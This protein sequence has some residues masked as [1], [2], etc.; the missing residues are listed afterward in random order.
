MSRDYT[1]GKIYCI[2]NNVDDD[3]YIGSTTQALSKRM[4]KH[5]SNINSKKA[6]H[7]IMYK[8][9]KELGI[10]H[11]YIELVK[12]FPCEALEQ[13]RAEEG[14]LIREIGTLNSKIAGRNR[15]QHYEDNKPSILEQRKTY[16]E[17]NKEHI[18][19]QKEGLQ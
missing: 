8:K 13:L 18:L 4:A 5:R 11:F 1:N 9:M 6:G 17:H 3:I 14:K 15:Q 7:Y 16:Y 19:E 12:D 2:R 10:E